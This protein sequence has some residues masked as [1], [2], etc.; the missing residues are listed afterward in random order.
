MLAIN[1]VITIEEAVQRL[2]PTWEV[3]IQ[4]FGKTSG[5]LFFP[6]AGLFPLFANPD[7]ALPSVSA[8]AIGPRS[9]LDR[10]YVTWDPQVTITDPNGL[11]YFRRL[12]IKA[13]LVFDQLG[14]TSRVLNVGVILSSIR[15][16]TTP[17]VS[18]SLTDDDSSVL[19]PSTFTPSGSTAPIPFLL[20]T[21]FTAEQD[22]N[23]NDPR[24]HLV[25]YLRPPLQSPPTDR[26][27]YQLDY[28]F[29]ELLTSPVAQYVYGGAMPVH[30]RR[31]VDFIAWTNSGDGASRYDIQIGGIKHGLGRTTGAP[32]P[33]EVVFDSTTLVNIAPGT[34]KRL[35]IQNPG[36]DYITFWGRV[37]A[38]AVTNQGL[39]LRAWAVDN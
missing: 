27:Q 30:G 25:F 17:F 8:I 34:P 12:S 35:Q 32:N 10:C 6:S 24:L 26:H 15:I 9:Q 11:D 3:E 28:L 38:G 31:V 1:Q 22:R 16:T 2:H 18:N 29:G 13:P 39:F 4:A 21:R 7:K 37:T 20:D 33:F 36:V 5:D 23:A 19:F 14:N